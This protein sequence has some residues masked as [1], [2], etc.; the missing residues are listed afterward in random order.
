MMRLPSALG[1]IVPARRTLLLPVPCHDGG[2]KIERDVVELQ[3]LEEPT[4]QTVEHT[5]IPRLR[6][7][8]EVPHERLMTRH[9]FPTEQI[10]D[11]RIEPRDLQVLEPIGSA[12]D[13]HPEMI[14]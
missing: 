14:D 8:P 1:R 7:F 11:H 5:M 2:V 4:I 9:A 10:G 3:L 13:A 6:E 12:P